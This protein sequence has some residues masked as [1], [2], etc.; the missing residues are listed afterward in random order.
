MHSFCQ[1]QGMHNFGGF[2]MTKADLNK[3]DYV[4]MVL[5]ITTGSN[6]GAAETPKD[7]KR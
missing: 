3:K 1:E 4:T 7:G 6:R 2:S 5:A